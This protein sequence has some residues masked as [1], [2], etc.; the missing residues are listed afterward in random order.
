MN[1]WMNIFGSAY[2]FSIHLI[3]YRDCDH[4]SYLA[5]VVKYTS[6]FKTMAG[7]YCGFNVI[8]KKMLPSELTTISFIH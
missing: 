5:L 8:Q 6:E 2:T 1:G 7:W 4:S 3:I